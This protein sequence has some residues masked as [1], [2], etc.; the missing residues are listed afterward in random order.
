M[1]VSARFSNDTMILAGDIGGTK[2]NLAL[3]DGKTR[4]VEKRYE[5]R[6]FSCFEEIL[7]DFLKINDTKLERACFGV[8]GQVIEGNCRL[9]NLSWQI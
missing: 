9:T 7:D 8:G 3:Y 6:N 5:S 1:S 2:V 4:A